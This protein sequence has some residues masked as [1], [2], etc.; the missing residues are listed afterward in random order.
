MLDAA[1]KAQPQILGT[2]TLRPLDEPGRIV[3]ANGPYQQPL[4]APQNFAD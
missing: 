4:A 1:Q 3:G 2:A